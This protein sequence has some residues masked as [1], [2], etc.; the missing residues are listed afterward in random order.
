M[1]IGVPEFEARLVFEP[2]FADEKAV[3][4]A[5][6]VLFPARFFGRSHDF[7]RDDRAV[8]SCDLR[9]FQLA[10][11]D[12]LDLV[13]EAES[14]F[15]YFR[16]GNGG[17]NAVAARDGEDWSSMSIGIG[18][19]ESLR[20]DVRWLSSSRKWWSLR[21]PRAEKSWPHCTIAAV[22]ARVGFCS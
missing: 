10:R 19:L 5:G 1:E 21:L 8:G 12:L 2:A 20:R 22:G 6:L 7:A 15:C 17:G 3:D 14:Y 4:H 18:R 16:G 13:F 9:L 11:D